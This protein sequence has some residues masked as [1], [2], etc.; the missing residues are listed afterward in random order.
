MHL[1]YTTGTNAQ[2][3]LMPSAITTHLEAQVDYCVQWLLRVLKPVDDPL[4]YYIF[5]QLLADQ[6]E[7]VRIEVESRVFQMIPMEHKTNEYRGSQAWY[8]D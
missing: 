8:L 2:L 4:F 7:S 6:P 3:V 5:E 1:D